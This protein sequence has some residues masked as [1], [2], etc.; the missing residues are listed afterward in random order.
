MSHIPT[1][2]CTMLPCCENTSLAELDM[3]HFAPSDC[4]IL[5]CGEN[6]HLAEFDMYYFATPALW[7]PPH[8]LLAVQF[9]LNVRILIWQNWTCPL[10]PPMVVQFF[11]GW[12]Y[13]PGKIK[14][15]SFCQLWFSNF[16]LWWE[17]LSGR[18]GHV[19]FCNIWLSNSASRWEILHSQNQTSHIL[20][21]LVVQ[22]CFGVRIPIWQN[23]ICLILPTLV[24]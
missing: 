2:S 19:L 13:P 24:L 17:Y 11:L 16:T 10:L 3:S 7:R 4:T 22:F 21:P 8:L 18:I 20:P 5:P 1:F 9:C 15:V 14:Y 12:E 23:W 6:T